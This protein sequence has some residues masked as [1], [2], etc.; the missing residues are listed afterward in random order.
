MTRYKKGESG[1]PAGR[2]KGA[3]GK[4]TQIP[5]SLTK[6]AITHLTRLIEE[7]DTT[8]IKL[9]LDRTIPAL[10]ATTAPGTLDAELLKLKIKELS[11]FEERLAALE[12]QNAK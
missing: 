11:E 2:P 7:G 8:A 9:V 1:N 12:A 4:K 3:L 6:Q 5:E 10:K